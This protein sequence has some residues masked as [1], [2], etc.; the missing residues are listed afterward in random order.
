MIEDTL[1]RRFLEEL[2]AKHQE[3]LARAVYILRRMRWH[4]GA[5]AAQR[6][7]KAEQLLHDAIL[8][9]LG[10]RRVWDPGH[11]DVVR[12]LGEIVRS[13]VSHE[14]QS[15]VGRMVSFDA[16]PAHEA[17]E[18]APDWEAVRGAPSEGGELAPLGAAASPEDILLWR[19]QQRERDERLGRAIK[20]VF[21]AAGDDLAIRAVLDAMLEGECR[22][23]AQV[24]ARTGMQV[25]EVYE[26]LRRLRRRLGRGR[27][28]PSQPPLEERGRR[29]AEA[30]AEA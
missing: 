29:Q 18:I 22:R 14:M 4:P 13:L 11:V 26:A 17:V 30:G 9:V 28:A 20:E 24:A 19:E 10:G 21:V 2:E 27:V 12:F 1:K 25:P 6:R 5:E 16:W 7:D 3:A 23:P 15:I 8:L